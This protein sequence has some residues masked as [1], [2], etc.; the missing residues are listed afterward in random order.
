MCRV[1]K[2]DGSIEAFDQNK[3]IASI[4]KETG[5]T[6]AV[7]D[8]IV[9]EVHSTLKTLRIDP[10]TGPLIRE[11]VNVKFLE[12]GMTDCR[13]KYARVGMPIFDAR[14]ADIGGGKGDNANLGESP[15]TAHKRK[16][17]QLSKEQA[18]LM[19]PDHIAEAHLNGYLHIHDMEYITAR[20]FCIDE[21]VVIPI[22][23]GDYT[24]ILKFSDLR[25][26]GDEIQP[27]DLYAFTP[28]GKRKIT[29]ITRRR[30]NA[31]E[32]LLVKTNLGKSIKV[33]KKHRVPCF[34]S[35]GHSNKKAK[36]LLEG[37]ILGHLKQDVLFGS[38]LEELNVVEGFIHAVP[39]DI[40][41]TVFVRNVGRI[42]DLIKQEN[43]LTTKSSLARLLNVPSDHV[44][45]GICK[46]VDFWRI[47]NEYHIVDYR[48][49]VLA[50]AGIQRTIPAYLTLTP[51]FM[52]MLGYFVSDGSYNLN[53][54]D[55]HYNLVMSRDSKAEYFKSYFES[56][57]SY[58]TIGI[59]SWGARQVYWGG[60]M[61]YLIF[62][63][64]LKIPAYAQN[65]RIPWIVFNTTPDLRKAF[66]SG[67]FSSDGTVYY[68]PDESSCIVNYTTTSDALRQEIL[69]LLTSLGI[70]CSSHCVKKYEHDIGDN[71]TYRINVCG[72]NTIKQF[73]E[74]CNFVNG[75]QHHVDTFLERVSPI[76]RSQKEGHVTKIQPI[77]PTSDWV[78]DISLEYSPNDIDHCFYAGDGILIHNC[79]DYDLR[80][81]FYYGFVGDGVGVHT[82]SAA[83]AQNPE[84]AIL[85]AVKTLCSGQTQKSGGQGFYNFLTFIAPYFKDCDYTRIKQ[86]MQMFIYEMSQNLVARGSQVCFSSVQLSPSVPEMW[87][88]KPAVFKGR[89]G[90]ETYGQFERE[91]RLLFKAFMEVMI[92]GDASNK[93]FYFPKPEI[94]FEPE[95]ITLM[96]REDVDPN[97]LQYPSIRELYLLAFKLAAKFGTPYFDNMI[98]QYR[99]AGKGIS[100][101]QCCS[102]NFSSG[103]DADPD[104]DDKLYFKD[105]KHFTM[106]S[107]QVITLNMPR[108]AFESG[109][110]Y[111]EL[112]RISKQYI[113][114][115]LEV[116]E[117]KLGWVNECEKN[118]MYPFAT[119]RHKDPNTKR[120]SPPLLDYSDYVNTLGII[121]INEV[122]EIMLGKPIYEDKAATLFAMRLCN[123][124]NKYCNELS[125]E[126]GMRLALSRTPAETTAQRFA[127]LDLLSYGDAHKHVKGSV[128]EAIRIYADT[129]SRDLPIYYTNGT[130][131]PVDADISLIDKIKIEQGFFP[132]LS[133]GNICNLY[134]GEKEPDPKGL[135]DF[136]LNICK[137]TNL[138][139]FAFTKEIT[140]CNDSYTEYTP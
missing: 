82:S 87:K 101:V 8:E 119:Q 48:D 98:P 116:F 124:L 105:G 7:I 46:I 96:E 85:H 41:E 138:G 13:K 79:A 24:S 59:G 93:P 115:A 78:Y 2:D 122:C 32:M 57:G 75:R 26:E 35:D 77:Q 94:A 33:T 43:G 40:L 56:L 18:I 63:Y 123:D 20:R 49:V 114:L 126:K 139:Y 25:F 135:M 99:G 6:G 125:K 17:D 38:P 132:L 9:D 37:D 19:F 89:I 22:S 12:R 10:V 31:D 136:T 74:V 88:D 120:L 4:K 34:T 29:S 81:I 67:L 131:C 121:G 86:N 103:P 106:G 95:F 27:S 54:I 70:Y 21:S 62:K 72:Y 73:N 108:Y 109:G 140:V 104:F 97:P 15:E 128:R 23:N 91:V 92:G 66:L 134:L 64:L 76:K 11:M 133:G 36:D 5:C 47:I 65:K 100:C 113:D 130:H 39:L 53:E 45:R 90:P 42:Y 61:W 107:N 51:Q 28:N 110:N 69:L 50:G 30:V 118:G 129:G 3:T 71:P 137:T 58:A 127:V 80:F 102:Y 68:T 83:P 111:D 44:L 52:E 14:R 84:V 16:A 117:I 60:K 1:R 112:V 55:H